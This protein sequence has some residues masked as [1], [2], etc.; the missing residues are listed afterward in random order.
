MQARSGVPLQACGT[1]CLC[2]R[3]PNIPLRHEKPQQNELSHQNIRDRYYGHNDPVARNILSNFAAKQGLTP[4]ED[5]SIVRDVFFVI[6]SQ[7]LLCM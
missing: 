2:L 7:R 3:P 1:F 4:P 5:K 6:R